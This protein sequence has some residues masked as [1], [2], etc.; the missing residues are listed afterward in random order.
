MNTFSQMNT[1]ASEFQVRQTFSDDAE[2]ARLKKDGT[3]KEQLDFAVSKF[4]E[5][6]LHMMMK[7]MRKTVLKSGL[8]D[9]DSAGEIYKDFLYASVAREAGKQGSLG[10]K[11]VLQ[12]QLN[13]RAEDIFG[14]GAGNQSSPQ[15]QTPIIDYEG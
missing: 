12:Q 9:S 3:R 15:A 6:M 2:A 11:Q 1:A 4:E 13:S 7:S 14:P 10:M 5:M 8:T